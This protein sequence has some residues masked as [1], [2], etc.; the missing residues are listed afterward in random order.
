M[1]VRCGCQTA[2]P[3]ADVAEMISSPLEDRRLLDFRD[4]KDRTG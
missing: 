3:N 4:L 2:V 1:I